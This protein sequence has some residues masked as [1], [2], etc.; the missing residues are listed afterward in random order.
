MDKME[1]QLAPPSMWDKT[2]D[3]FKKNAVPLLAGAAL[4][5]NPSPEV[6]AAIGKLSPQQKEYFNRPSVRWDWEQMQR[7]ADVT[8]EDLSSFINKNWSNVTGGK[9]NT[10]AMPRPNNTMGQPNTLPSVAMAHGGALSQ[11]AQLAQGPGSGRD[12][13]INARL[14]DGEYVIDAETVAM[15]GDGSTK[16]G[17]QKLDRLR[18]Q[19]RKHKGKSLAKG[20]FSPNARA[21]LDYIRVKGIA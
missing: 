10:K 20:K 4:L 12:D 16:N 18:E 1:A 6:K 13:T 2:T 5:S 17:S 7:D 21:P 9:Y 3:F 11:I 8:N 14:S 15:L 19:L